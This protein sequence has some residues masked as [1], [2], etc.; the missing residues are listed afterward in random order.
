MAVQLKASIVA[1]DEREG[2][3]RRLLNLGHTI[4]HAFEAAEGFGV[5]R[6]GDAVA[7]G[8]VAAFRVA[9][10]L[11]RGEE[12]HEMRCVRLLEALGLPVGIDG[13][14]TAEVLA[15]IGN[16]KKREGKRVRFIAPGAPGDV[17]VVPIE[18][19]RLRQWVALL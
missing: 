1:Q 7:L 11:G 5:L 15:L 12:A 17:D 6:H 4:G 3:R 19:E 14:G 8:M 2:S 16:D 10:A 9:R 13:R 18:L